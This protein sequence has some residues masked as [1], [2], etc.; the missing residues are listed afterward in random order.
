MRCTI[1]ILPNGPGLGYG[2]QRKNK[3]FKADTLNHDPLV[4][5]RDDEKEIEKFFESEAITLRERDQE[6]HLNYL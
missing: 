3:C 5:L 2:Q 1:D 6:P 4:I